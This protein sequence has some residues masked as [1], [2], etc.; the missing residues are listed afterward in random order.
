MRRMSPSRLRANG[1]L[2][3]IAIKHDYYLI[4]GPGADVRTYVIQEGSYANFPNIVSFL[5]V[6]IVS[7]KNFIHKQSVGSLDVGSGLQ[8]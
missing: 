6:P 7:L 4:E 8:G 2:N 3:F 1:A 5:R